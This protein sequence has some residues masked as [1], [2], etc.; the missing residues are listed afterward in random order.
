MVKA[1]LNRLPERQPFED[2]PFQSIVTAK[3]LILPAKLN[4]P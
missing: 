3:P 2:T 1:E 4:G